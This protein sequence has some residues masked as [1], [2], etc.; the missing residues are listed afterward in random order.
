MFNMEEEQH[1]MELSLCLSTAFFWWSDPAFFWESDL[2]ALT[3]GEQSSKLFM[4]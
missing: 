2:S 4:C 1:S 3:G